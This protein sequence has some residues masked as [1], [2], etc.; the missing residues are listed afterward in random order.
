MAIQLRS[1]LGSTFIV[2]WL[3]CFG[4]IACEDKCEVGQG[5]DITCEPGLAP[6]CIASSICDCVSFGGGEIPGGSQGGS[7]VAGGEAGD[8]PPPVCDPLLE[9]DL[10]INEVLINAPGSSE[11]AGEYIELVNTSAK[12]IDLTGVMVTY[13]SDE[14]LL[15]RQGCMAP[16]SAVAAF[17]GGS[18]QTPWIWSTPAQ[19]VVMD[20]KASF[21][22]SNSSPFEFLLYQRDGQPID[23]FS[24][25]ASLSSQD[26]ESATRSPSLSGEPVRHSEVS[27]VMSLSS[28]AMCSNSGT[29]EQ[30][31]ADGEVVTGGQTAGEMAGEMIA[32][33]VAGEMVGG[34]APTLNCDAPFVGDL[35]IN[36]VLINPDGDDRSGEFIEVVNVSARP[37]NLASIELWYNNSENVLERKFGFGSGCLAANS[38]FAIFNASNSV[39]WIWSSPNEYSE[40]LELGHPTFQ[41]NNERSAE[42]QLRAG[43]G[44]VLSRIVIPREMII[45]GV[46]ANRPSDGSEGGTVTRHDE[47][48]LN[49]SSPGL[50]SNGDRF[51]NGCGGQP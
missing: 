10:V 40:Q 4:L 43:S 31:C 16:Y 18:N 12:T 49:T 14:K 11:G 33:E 44:Q 15:F 37:V 19:G 32:G 1:R 20:T 5:C 2:S 51:E 6:V 30:L 35:V 3:A 25:A 34:G 47:V 27:P 26:G 7:S 38:A 41:L 28:P 39:S 8:V 21:S 29:F 42:I 45:S 50:C 24:G 36:E 9:G 48:G 23:L 22:F 46:S 17:G 13:N